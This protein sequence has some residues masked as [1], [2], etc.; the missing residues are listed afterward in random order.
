M[1]DFS[2][3]SK[4]DSKP[5]HSQ[6]DKLSNI[7]WRDYSN[8]QARLIMDCSHLRQVPTSHELVYIIW[9]EPSSTTLPFIAISEG[10]GE[11]APMCKL[12]WSFAAQICDEYLNH[13]NWYKQLGLI[14]HL[15]P[16][17]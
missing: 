17:F 12:V 10:S 1:Q 13:V 3:Y 9:S 11:T 15:H 7:I 14:L 2:L 16:L 4:M 6:E 8:V 5:C